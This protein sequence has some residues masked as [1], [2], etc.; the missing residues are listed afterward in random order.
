MFRQ[1]SV[2][3]TPAPRGPTVAQSD[4]RNAMA[5][6][7]AAVSIITTAGPAGRA[8]FTAAAVC[9]VTDDP[10]T[11]LVCVN[12]TSSVIGAFEGNGVLCVNLCT[13]EHQDLAMLF[14]G[15]TPSDERFAAA[16]WSG[17]ASGAPVLEAAPVAFDCRI[18]SG[19]DVGSHRVFFCGVE[20]IVSQDGA[21]RLI[22]CNRRFH[23]LPS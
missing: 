1:P 21:G 10:P 23:A 4:F 15:K 5:R 12:R 7:G 8:G 2:W 3:P 16:R 13:P 9:S 19:V 22:Y 14:G 11:L 6:L 17:L 18:V 20:A